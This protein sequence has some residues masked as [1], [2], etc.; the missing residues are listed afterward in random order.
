MTEHLDGS[1]PPTKIG[2]KQ[3]RGNGQKNAHVYGICF[4]SIILGVSFCS[5]FDKGLPIPS[6][7]NGES[8]RLFLFYLFGKCFIL[9]QTFMDAKK[10]GE[11]LRMIRKHLGIN[12]QE[13][14]KATNLTQPTI[15]RLENGEEVYASAL[16]A[17]LSFYHD[18]ISLDQLFIMDLNETNHMLLYCSRRDIV[19]RLEHQIDI[20]THD[21]NKS[22]EKIKSLKNLF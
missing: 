22:Q 9:R 20:I 17:L 6:R 19:N 21:L 12:Q 16:L 5:L 7:N 11:R 10:L 18:K 8:E 4:A 1:Y 2:K 13:L 14:A 15:S 3:V